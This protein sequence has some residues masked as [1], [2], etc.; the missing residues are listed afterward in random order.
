MQ[1]KG[2][3]LLSITLLKN[4]M[5]L[6]KIKLIISFEKVTIIVN[7][8]TY[9]LIINFTTIFVEHEQCVNNKFLEQHKGQ[10]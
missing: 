9:D 7:E 10:L 2:K 1:K 5:F 3:N 4:D 8:V 6:Y